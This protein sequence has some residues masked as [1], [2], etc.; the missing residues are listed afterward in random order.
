MAQESQGNGPYNP[1][2]LFAGQSPHVAP[3][4]RYGAR[5]VS[6]GDIID[7]IMDRPPLGLIQMSGGV[8]ILYT[9]PNKGSG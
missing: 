2:L 9:A 1:S 4:F 6:V 7:I 3:A 8:S 5:P